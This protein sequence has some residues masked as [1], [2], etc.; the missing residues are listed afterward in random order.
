MR[1]LPLRTLAVGSLALAALAAGSSALAALVPGSLALAALAPGAEDG[2]PSDAPALA[3]RASVE[4]AFAVA[5]HRTAPLDG[6]PGADLL[7][8]GAAGEVRTHG[9]C[10]GVARGALSLPEPSRALL[11]VAEVAEDGGAAELVL[12]SPRGIEAWRADG[13]GAYGGE[14]LA[15][16]GRARMRWRTGAPAFAP[17]ARDVDADGRIDLLVPARDALELWVPAPK[18]EARDGEAAGFRR[19]AR[20]AV[21]VDVAREVEAEHLS[22]RLSSR[23]SIPD[24]ST[25]DVDGDGRE[26]LL[27]EHDTR[28]GFH[29]VRAGGEIPAE[30]DVEVDLAIF[31]DTTPAAGLEPGRTLAGGEQTS[32]LMRD[33]DGDGV[34]DYVIAH[35]RK[36]W[37]FHGTR[38]GPQF[39]EP[40]TILKA[41]DDV[42]ALVVLDLDDDEFPDL[43]LFKVQVPSVGELLRG[44]LREWDVRIDAIGY[45]SRAGR[46][47]DPSPR[48]RSSVSVRLPA[49]LSIARDPE[50]LITRFEAV[51]R[52]F[53]TPVEADF[54]GDGAI[55]VALVGEDRTRI[56]LWRAR[57]TGAGGAESDEKILRRLLFE[58]E[59]KEW[60]IERILGWLGDYAALRVER[61]TGGRPPDATFALRDRAAF[62]LESLEPA[63]AD[64][65]GGHELLLRYGRRGDPGRKAF[66]LVGLRA[67]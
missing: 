2:A 63:D 57:E 37:V 56:E 48:W 47:F 1:E 3:L 29:L 17:I 14:P 54:D 23:V 58:D 36:V 60:D 50:A 46:G 15:L 62:E 39:T 33:L 19:A 12:L 53:R 59:R 41:A 25:E 61:T 42:T 30:P 10:A 7:V 31:R 27:V 66:D 35:R 21:E 28:R 65:D 55:D 24:L 32:F 13:D 4:P 20:V 49:I 40:T 67:R 8:V 51:G 18:G 6:A 16:A 38:A 9:A 52:R 44:L 64:G 34:P 22:D 43:L 11:A 5:D 26:D 45:A